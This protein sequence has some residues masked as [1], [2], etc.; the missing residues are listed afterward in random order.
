MDNNLDKFSDEEIL[1]F[2]NDISK[3]YF[4]RNFGTMSKSDFETLIFSHYIEHYLNSGVVL[5]D[6]TLSK[7]LGLTQNRVRALKERKELKYPYENFEWEKAFAENIKNAK[8]DKLAQRIK[9]VIDDVNVITEV[10]H[11][12]EMLGYYDEY[13]LNKRIL[14]M[15]LDGFLDLCISLSN[16]NIFT[17]EAKAKIEELKSIENV[18]IQSKIKEFLLNFTKDGL[19]DLAKAVPKTLLKTVLGALPF[20]GYA[21][22]AIDFLAELIE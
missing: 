1:K 14:Q 3:A 15:P 7:K 6:Y 13:Q 5:D 10:R 8:Y 12:I 17:D 21:G 4:N 11:R 18:D 19:C 9:I 16:E 20:G 2:Y 22:I